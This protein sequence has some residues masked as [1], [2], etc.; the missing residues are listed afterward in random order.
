M[1]RYDRVVS[2]GCSMTA[3]DELR[4]F[5]SCPLVCSKETY[6]GVIADRLGVEYKCL[7]ESGMGND[8]IF[9]VL[10]NEIRCGKLTDRDLVIIGWSGIHRREYYLSDTKKWISMFSAAIPNTK[11]RW[12]DTP[13]NRDIEDLCEAYTTEIG[14]TDD[15]A[16]VDTFANYVWA[17][18]GVLKSR[19]IN[20]I[21]SS[22][23]WS[24][25]LPLPPLPDSFYT[26]DTFMSWSVSRYDRHI[27]GHPVEEAHLGWA[28]K[29]L[30]LVA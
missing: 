11:K 12:K 26:D 18:D 20:A 30:G 4:G 29:L 15:I 25:N 8:G 5:S 7:A 22:T 24:T 23:V 27:G 6:A 16:L 10:M 3:G 2:F 19:G 17:I 28:D 9:R 14:I 21:M 1:K 13:Y